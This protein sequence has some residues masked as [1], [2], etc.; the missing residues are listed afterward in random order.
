MMQ[1]L[2]MGIAGNT[3][4]PVNSLRNVSG[5]LAFRGGGSR[6]GSTVININAGLGTDSYELGRVVSAALK[7]YSGVSGG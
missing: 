3:S 6:G 1:G 4:L 2:A 7:K 5:A